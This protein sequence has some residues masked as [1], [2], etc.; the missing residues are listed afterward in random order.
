[1]RISEVYQAIEGEGPLVG[2]PNWI[3]R[4]A[5]CN[6]RCPGWPC[7]SPYAIYPELYRQDW[8]NVSY[9]E[10][11]GRVGRWPELVNFSGGEPWQQN[12]NEMHAL[13]R[14]LKEQG[15]YFETFTNGSRKIPDWVFADP[16]FTITMDWKLPGS[17]EGNYVPKMAENRLTNLR[18]LKDTDA[19]KFVCLNKVDFD[20]AVD[21]WTEEILGETY[22]E[23]YVGPVWDKCDPKDLSDWLLNSQ[24]PWKLSIQSHNY[25][26]GGNVERGI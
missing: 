14:T 15:H 20:S 23:I 13:Y 17:G 1:M 18:R 7:D 6:L 5:G 8:D 12:V 10:V 3:V 2:T 19:I 9:E 16:M 11:A 22:A 25:I 26:H 24:L 21:I 4:F